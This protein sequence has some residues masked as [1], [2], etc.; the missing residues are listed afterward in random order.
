MNLSLLLNWA[1]FYLSFLTSE[2]TSENKNKNMDFFSQA[3]NSDTHAYVYV[4]NNGR[5]YSH[6]TSKWLVFNMKIMSPITLWPL[7]RTPGHSRSRYTTTT[8]GNPS[9]GQN[10]DGMLILGDTRTRKR[11][12][13]KLTEADTH[14]SLLPR[15]CA[16][17]LLC[18]RIHH[19][20]EDSPAC[21]QSPCQLYSEWITASSH[22]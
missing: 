12:F 2:A 17:L 5:H 11:T 8:A 18:D 4:Y 15:G 9:L 6:A 7:F 19:M 3:C 10:Y 22:L 16:E 13:L 1:N 21:A 20:S 14:G